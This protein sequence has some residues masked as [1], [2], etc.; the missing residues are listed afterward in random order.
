[1][2][3]L[4]KQHISGPIQDAAGGRR[5]CAIMSPARFVGPNLSDYRFSK[6]WE[7]YLNPYHLG[8]GRTVKRFTLASPRAGGDTGRDD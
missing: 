7:A 6:L 1:M 5:F 4:V 2:A 3:L 8:R